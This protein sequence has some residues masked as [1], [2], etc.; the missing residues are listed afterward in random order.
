MDEEINNEK[1]NIKYIEIDQNNKFIKDRDLSPFPN[2][3][4]NNQKEISAK[5]NKIINIMY[6]D[7]FVLMINELSSSI[8]KFHKEMNQNFIEIK[9]IIQGHSEETEE[10]SNNSFNIEYNTSN[11]NV[12]NL[13][14]NFS[15]IQKS[16]CDFYS[17]A[18]IIFKK[19]KNYR[20]EK[21]KHINESAN[22]LQNSK[23]LKFCFVKSCNNMDLKEGKNK[24]L[25]NKIYGADDINSENISLKNNLFINEKNIISNEK[26]EE[27]DCNNNVLKTS[28]SNLITNK[29][30]INDIKLLLNILKLEKISNNNYSPNNNALDNKNDLLNRKE[31]LFKK[32]SQ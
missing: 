18:K 24:M 4:N 26:N 20:N 22:E 9:Q 5:M 2:I 23:F 12:N 25:L 1:N 27:N 3:E 13:I 10:N 19:M 30:F 28:L 11:I 16:F 15:N 29:V 8:K 17:K 7:N 14:N 6:D 21:I 32:I 31:E